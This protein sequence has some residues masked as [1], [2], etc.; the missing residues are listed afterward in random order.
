MKLETENI[1]RQLFILFFV[2]E[3][4][5]GSFSLLDADECD[6]INVA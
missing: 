3:H 2:V 4:K 6:L 1:L 5:I